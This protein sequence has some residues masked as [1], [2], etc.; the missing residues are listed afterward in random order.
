MPD[1]VPTLFA[2]NRTASLPYRVE[3]VKMKRSTRSA[4]SSFAKGHNYNKLSIMHWALSSFAKDHNYYK[5]L[6]G[7]VATQTDDMKAHCAAVQV[8]LGQKSFRTQTTQ[9]ENQ[10]PGRQRR[11]HKLKRGRVQPVR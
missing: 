5:E 4:L 2:W 6:F 11:R 7:Y 1:A 10:D 8:N 9:T 3:T